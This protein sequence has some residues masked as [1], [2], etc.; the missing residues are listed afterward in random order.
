VQLAPEYG[1]G[2]ASLALA[3]EVVYWTTTEA[4]RKQVGDS[5][6]EMVAATARAALLDPHAAM[7]LHA[8]GNVARAQGR[9]ADA[10]GLYRAAIQA[11]PSYPDVREDYIEAL[12][13]VGDAKE[14]EPAIRELLKLDPH[15]TLFWWRLA[16]LG[17]YAQR[18]ELVD[19]ALAQAREVDTDSTLM[20]EVPMYWTLG[21]GE[22]EGARKA[23]AGIL[24]RH[25]EQEATD[26]V[27]FHWAA[28]DP[29]ADEAR[30]RALIEEVNLRAPYA[31]LRGDL[32]LVLKSYENEAAHMA[33]HG[34]YTTFAAPAARHWLS[35]PQ[36]RAALLRLGF[37]G[38]WREHGWPALCRAKGNDDF[39]CG[40]A[41]GKG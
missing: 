18:Q 22:V 26:G 41:A 12:V 19:E 14:A 28:R 30:A 1:A 20:R 2:W 11:D 33:R 21:R 29:G 4:Q 17:L 27:M 40:Q 3:H 23:L 31:V 10:L 32:E 6:A 35:D 38:Y 8:Q 34:F 16:H 36:V 15:N 13:S 39:E 7:T 25:P 9:F 5:Y 37:V 24:A